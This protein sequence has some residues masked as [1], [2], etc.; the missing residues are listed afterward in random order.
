MVLCGLCKKSFDPSV[1]W[2]LRDTSPSNDILSNVRICHSCA[3]D[4]ISGI[5]MEL[6]QNPTESFHVASIFGGVKLTDSNVE[7]ALL[8]DSSSAKRIISKKKRS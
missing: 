5:M 3:S 6:G 2:V 8:L 4:V 1:E 7:I